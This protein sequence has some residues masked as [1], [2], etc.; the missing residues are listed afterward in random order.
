MA[1]V[2]TITATTTESA[3][4]FEATYQYMWFRNFGETDCYISEHS[5]II[6]EADNVTLLKAGEIAMLTIPQAPAHS[7]AYIKAT[8]GS[9]S[10]EVHAQNS[11]FCPFKKLAKG[12]E[13]IDVIALNVTENDTYT[14][15][16]GTAYSPV[17]VTVPT[18]AEIITRSDW[19][20]LTTAQKQAKGLVA[21]QDASTGFK[22]G[23]FVNGADYIEAN[24]YI[25]YSNNDSVLC[26]AYVDN[27]DGTSDTWGVG[28]SPLQYVDDTHKP[29]LDTTENAVYI[30]TKTNGVVP[31]IDVG[32]SQKNYTI[33]FIARIPSPTGQYERLVSCAYGYDS[34][35]SSVICR[36]N[37]SDVLMFSTWAMIQILR[38]I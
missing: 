15:P 5:G 8:S 27:F 6:A 37:N 28:T 33:Y 3:V 16:S 4:E 10:V 30:Q 9:N 17:T 24:K 2:K 23:E 14:A 31:Y 12:G 18:G 35:N 7:T 13:E 20:A 21:I 11:A 26:E 29:S 34:G 1:N 38:T 22:R 25:P 19:N 32:D 36:S